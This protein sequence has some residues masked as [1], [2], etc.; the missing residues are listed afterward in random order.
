MGP[1]C[2][3]RKINCVYDMRGPVPY[4]KPTLLASGAAVM[5]VVNGVTNVWVY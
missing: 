2:S 1:S 3:I 5:N 4:P